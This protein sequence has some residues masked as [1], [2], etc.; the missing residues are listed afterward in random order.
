[1]L[2]GEDAGQERCWWERCWL[3]KMLAEEDAG[4]KRCWWE[5]CWLGKMLVG[6]WSTEES[7]L[8]CLPAIIYSM[9]QCV[10]KVQLKSIC[11]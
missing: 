6:I 1:M 3:G 9:I 4:R 11:L 5:R 10:Q 7:L 2:V 8:R